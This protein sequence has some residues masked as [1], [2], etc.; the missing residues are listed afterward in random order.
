MSGAV[1]PDVPRSAASAVLAAVAVAGAPL[2]FFLPGWVGALFAAML[3]S[4][5]LTLSRGTRLPPRWLL[6]LVV[7]VPVGLLWLSLNTLVGREGGVALFLLLLG[8]KAFETH[9]LRDWQ[10]LLA[11]GFFLAATPLLFDQSPLAALWL[12]LTIAALTVAMAQ[13]AGFSL[14]GGARAAG[15]AMALGLPLALLLFLLV[16]RLPG[17]L[18]NLPRGDNSATTGLAEEMAPGSISRLIPNRAPAFTV[19]FDGRTPSPSARYWRV[20]VLDAFDGRAWRYA[21]QVTTRESAVT[22]GEPLDYWLTA[23]P[24]KGRLP[25]LDWPIA[26]PQGV[27]AAPGSLYQMAVPANEAVRIKGRSA[28]GRVLH[29]ALSPAQ[30]AFY[31][32]LPPGNPRT[33]AEARQSRAAAVSDSTWLKANLDRFRLRGFRYTLEPPPLS[34]DIVDGF[35]FDTRAGFCEHYAGSLAFLARAAGI[36]SRVV[37]GYQGGEYNDVG[38][39]WQVRSSDAHA[40]A[41]LWLAEEGGWVRVDPTAAVSP[42]RV[43]AGA[44]QILPAARASLPVVGAVAPDW[45]RGLEERWMAARFGWEQWVLGFDAERQRALFA[46]LG[47]GQGVNAAS[48]L[49]GLL[50]GGALALLPLLWWAWRRRVQAPPLVRAWRRLQHKLAVAGIRVQDSDGPLEMRS[51]AKSLPDDDFRRVEALLKAYVALRYRSRDADPAAERAWCRAVARLR[52]AASRRS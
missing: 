41:E 22:G 16:P 46:G 32:A 2:V 18:W 35:L 37:V 15:R 45:L 42:E 34:G 4:R 8:F 13:L 9:T 33:L 26:L 24:D 12:M 47:L 21:D 40:W 31:L 23:T 6:A 1:E 48:V 43:E 29:E 20:R 14:R 17:P 27:R 50:A 25:A 7:T 28:D 52:I 10:V 19:V 30:R 3:A 51:R 11:L 5:G 44:A 49:R 38:R 39:F 36:P